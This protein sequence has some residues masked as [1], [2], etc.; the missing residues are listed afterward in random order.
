MH[1]TCWIF[2][3]RKRYADALS[4]GLWPFFFFPSGLLALLFR[5]WND[6]SRRFF[7]DPAGRNNLP[8]DLQ[9]PC[10][11]GGGSKLRSASYWHH[12]LS[13]GE[14]RGASERRWL[15]KIWIGG[16]L[17]VGIER[18]RVGV[19]APQNN[20]MCEEFLPSCEFEICPE[21]E[22]NG[23]DIVWKK[24][25]LG[26]EGDLVMSRQSMSGI[27]IR[28]PCSVGRFYSL[29]IPTLPKS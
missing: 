23:R 8:W 27:R 14:R 17:L 6:L 29:A 9:M 15:S 25:R 13:W 4:T 26:E 1:A 3:R 19:G 12:T 24:L 16:D 7:L 21:E 2:L 5:P 18:K 28:V 11:G 10:R 22:R 20:A